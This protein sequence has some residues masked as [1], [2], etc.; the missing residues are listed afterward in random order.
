[1]LQKSVTEF[2]SPCGDAKIY[3]SSDMPIGVFH[4]FLMRMKGMM[5]DKMIKFQR[6]QEEEAEQHLKMQAQDDCAPEATCGESETL[7]PV[8]EALVKDFPID[9]TQQTCEASNGGS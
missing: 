5:V 2:I 8:E 6:E 9:P 7:P 1:M 4:D 3:V